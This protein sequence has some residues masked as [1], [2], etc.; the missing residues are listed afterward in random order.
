MINE[1]LVYEDIVSGKKYIGDMYYVATMF[2]KRYQPDGL[3]AIEIREKIELWVRENNKMILYDINREINRVLRGRK[4]FQEFKPTP[5]TRRDINF[6]NNC[7]STQGRKKV[8]FALLIYGKEYQ[9]D[10]GEFSISNR[11]FAEWI[12]FVNANNLYTRYY[13][14]LVNQRLAENLTENYRIREQYICDG[15][16]VFRIPYLCGAT[17]K[18]EI[19]YTINDNNISQWYDKIFVEHDRI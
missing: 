5:V 2:A 3:T 17:D 13:P 19:V 7:A 18:T 6:I 8:M 10:I 15:Y 4:S 9:N 11:I 14:W 12:G 16:S 1:K